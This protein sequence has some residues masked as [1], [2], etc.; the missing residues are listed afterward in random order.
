VKKLRGEP[1]ERSVEQLLGAGGEVELVP[2]LIPMGT[3]AL[4][5]EKAREEKCTAAEVFER[6]IAQYF[7]KPRENQAPAEEPK[8]ASVQPAIVVKKKR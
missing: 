7:K 2:V 4:I 8:R 6:A 5:L 3:Y 1:V